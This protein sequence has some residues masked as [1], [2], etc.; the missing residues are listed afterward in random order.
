MSKHWC[1]TINNPKASDKVCPLQFEYL[2]IGIEVGEEGTP[3][4]QGYCAFKTRRRLTGAKKVWPRA[5]LEIKKGTVLQAIDYC[6]KDGKF[7][8]WGQVPQSRGEATKTMWDDVWENAKSGNFEAIPKNILS[9]HYN[10]IKRIRQDHPDKPEDLK[11][12]DNYWIVAPSG[13]GKSTYA[14]NRWPDYFDKGPNKWWTG[15]QGEAY[16]ICDDFGPKHCL[17]LGW[18][19]KRWADTFS[20]PMETKGGGRQIRPK[21]IIVT[22]QY[23]IS[24][25]FNYDP[26]VVDAIENRFTVI[27]LPHWDKSIRSFFNKM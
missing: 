4:W 13:Y 27:D 22:S 26:L 3:H 19:M 25:C 16:V 2:I 10:N 18:Y 6:K 5:H 20:F 15:Y 7:E 23:S 17:H 8:E 24:D 9:R 11:K 14:R 1:F 12:K 21:S